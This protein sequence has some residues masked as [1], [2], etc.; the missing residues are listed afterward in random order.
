MKEPETWEETKYKGID[1]PYYKGPGEHSVRDLEK[2]CDQY[3]EF[4]YQRQIWFQTARTEAEARGREIERE[5]IDTR[6]LNRARMVVR[7]G[8]PD[9]WHITK[10]E[11]NE[12]IKY[13]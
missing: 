12:V 8:K 9:E 7:E 2:I 1:E 5:E 11:W 3:K 13:E 6:F 10:Q 4:C